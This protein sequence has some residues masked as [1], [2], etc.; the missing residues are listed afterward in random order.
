MK[1]GADAIDKDQA[2][3]PAAAFEAHLRQE[4]RGK[5]MKRHHRGGNEV[6]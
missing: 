2:H 1:H 5:P 6:A 4:M 3:Q